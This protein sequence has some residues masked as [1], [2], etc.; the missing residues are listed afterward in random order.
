MPAGDAAF[1]TV[2]ASTTDDTSST[3][4]LSVT[5][6]VTYSAKPVGKTTVELAELTIILPKVLFVQSKVHRVV[7]VEAAMDATTIVVE[8]ILDL[9]LL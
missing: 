2:R 3:L 1:C 5:D 8:F 9:Q 7:G 4:L 6:T